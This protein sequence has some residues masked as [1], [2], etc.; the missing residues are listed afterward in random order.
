MTLTSNHPQQPNLVRI[1]AIDEAESTNE[2]SQVENPPCHEPTL[3]TAKQLCLAEP[4]LTMGGIR[5]LLFTKGHD[6][7]GVYRFGRKLLFDRAEF[8]E[9]IKQGHTANISGRGA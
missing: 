4:A 3:L 2:T 1:G 6:L 9:G 7:P 8:M 5:H